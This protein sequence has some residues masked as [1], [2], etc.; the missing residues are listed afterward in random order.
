MHFH[1]TIWHALSANG[2]HWNEWRYAV[3]E[4]DR[5]SPLAY[6]HAFAA[7]LALCD[8]ITS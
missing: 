3:A 2:V 5:R 4:E 1:R 7:D 8:R 6:W